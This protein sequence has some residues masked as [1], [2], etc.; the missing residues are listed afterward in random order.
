MV[1]S[2]TQGIGSILVEAEYNET[3]S[4]L[5]LLVIKEQGISLLGCDWFN[6]LGIILTGVHQVHQQSVVLMLERYAEV[7]KEELEACHSLPVTID[8]DHAVTPKFLKARP[9]P[10]A[11]CPKAVHCGDTGIPESTPYPVNR[12]HRPDH[13]QCGK[14]TTDQ[15]QGAEERPTT[16]KGHGG[17]G[18][19][20]VTYKPTANDAKVY[21][22]PRGGGY[23]PLGSGSGGSS[24][25]GSESGGSSPLGSESGGSSPL[26][27]ASSGCS[28]LLELN[29]RP[30]T[31]CCGIS[32][33]SQCLHRQIG[34]FAW[35]AI[36]Y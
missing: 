1:P 3:K 30:L 22:P 10:F 6:A 13:Q 36:G 15:G 21:S 16:M 32:N 25:L 4:K 27:S 17:V 23:S 26:G 31:V 28:S 9:V 20:L 35:N 34:I 14:T 7:F 33:S 18:K 24:P 19:E 29:F 12:G 5:P 2:T 8:V 11:L